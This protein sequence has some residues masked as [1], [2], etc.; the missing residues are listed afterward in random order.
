MRSFEL[1][2]GKLYKLI[3]GR[4]LWYDISQYKDKY[5]EPGNI[6]LFVE[7]KIFVDGL[8]PEKL[9]VFLD[10]DGGLLWF[11]SQELVWLDKINET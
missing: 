4:W 9:Y 3:C 6:L 8:G 5:L 11:E 1:K 2:S 7:P 10:Q